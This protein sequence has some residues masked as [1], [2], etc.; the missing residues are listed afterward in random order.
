M[1]S[2]YLFTRTIYSILP[3]G[4]ANWPFSWKRYQQSECWFTEQTC[5]LV[6]LPRETFD[7]GRSKWKQS[8]D[9]NIFIYFLLE[10]KDLSYSNKQSHLFMAEQIK[11]V[12][13]LRK[14]K[15]CP[16]TRLSTKILLWVYNQLRCLSFCT[17]N[18]STTNTKKLPIN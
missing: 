12:L 5:Q 7:S 10:T 14:W 1:D 3:Q 8:V 18:F 17:N 11:K 15:E 9:F 4:L 16:G 2:N 6:L 13:G